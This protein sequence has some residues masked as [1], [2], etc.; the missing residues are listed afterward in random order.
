[1]IFLF[2]VPLWFIG[3]WLVGGLVFAIWD[4]IDDASCERE[5]R[6]DRL[7]ANE[8]LEELKDRLE[9]KLAG[10]PLQTYVFLRKV[11]ESRQS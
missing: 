11:A 4:A 8:R 10:L 5:A 6:E 1:M 3:L 9:A 2:P 7:A